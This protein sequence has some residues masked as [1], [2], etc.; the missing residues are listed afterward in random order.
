MTTQPEARISR[1][2]LTELRAAG[3]FAFKVHGS[4]YMMSG[5]PDVIACVDG[6]FVGFEVKVPGKRNNT[7]DVQKQVHQLIKAAKGYPFVVC[8]A[9][10]AMAMV[11]RIRAQLKLSRRVPPKPTKET[12]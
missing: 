4:E 5:L 12:S 7:S 6:I 2:I 10:E 9:A 8:S 3:I 11:A 1:A